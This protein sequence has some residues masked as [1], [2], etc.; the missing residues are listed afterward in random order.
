[1]GVEEEYEEMTLDRIINGDAHFPGMLGLVRAYLDSLSIDI[2]TKC[3]LAR[4]LDLV[5]SRANGHF[6]FSSIRRDERNSE[7]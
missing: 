4:Y 5:Q 3:E 2:I 6:T 7:K 1:M